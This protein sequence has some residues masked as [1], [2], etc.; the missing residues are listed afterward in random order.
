[1]FG[2]ILPMVL[3]LHEAIVS[4]KPPSTATSVFNSSFPKKLAIHMQRPRSA[5]GRCERLLVLNIIFPFQVLFSHLVSTRVQ[6]ACPICLV[7]VSSRFDQTYFHHSEHGPTVYSARQKLWLRMIRSD[8]S[9]LYTS[10]SFSRV[11]D[12]SKSTLL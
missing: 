12:Y 6:R 5:G 1:M 4:F 3:F 9:Q 2:I 7:A 10:V 11:H 8:Y